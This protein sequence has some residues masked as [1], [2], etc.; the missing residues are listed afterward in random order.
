MFDHIQPY[1]ER[2]PTFEEAVEIHRLLKRGF[3][4]SQIAALFETNN[5]RVSEINTGKRHY[6]SYDIAFG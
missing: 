5:G 6:G 3:P 4:Q 1:K 2:I